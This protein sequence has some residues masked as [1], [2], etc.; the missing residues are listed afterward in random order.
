MHPC[1]FSDGK[2]QKCRISPVAYRK[3]FLL[4]PFAVCCMIW[5]HMVREMQPWLSCYIYLMSVDI[6]TRLKLYNLTF[7]KSFNVV[8]FLNKFELSLYNRIVNINKN[9]NC[10]ESRRWKDD[11]YSINITIVILPKTRCS[12]YFI[13]Y[14]S[15]KQKNIYSQ[16]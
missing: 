16:F 6:Y 12:F 3:S 11:A 14:N 2:E 5:I 9:R 13:N 4:S 1:L 15:E 10:I 7:S 8:S